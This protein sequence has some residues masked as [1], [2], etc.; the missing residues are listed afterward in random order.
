MGYFIVILAVATLASGVMLFLLMQIMNLEFYATA[1]IYGL[2]RIG[3]VL[4]T[5]PL[6]GLVTIYMM[7]LTRP[8]P[9]PIT[10][11]QPDFVAFY[12]VSY[13]M[14]RGT[15][16]QKFYMRLVIA[17]WLLGVLV[18]T[19]VAVFQVFQFYRTVLKKSTLVTDPSILQL[20][21]TVRE[22]LGIRK[23]I[24]VHYH[25]SVQVPVLVILNSPR[26]LIGSTDFSPEELSWIIRHELVHLKRKHILFK[27]LGVLA[28]TLYWF[29][30]LIYY[31]FQFFSDYCELDC[32]RE[33]LKGRTGVQR[34]FYANLLLDLLSKDIPANPAIES[35]FCGRT[36]QKTIDRR[37]KNIIH[38]PEKK[39]RVGILALSV[40]YI[41]SCPFVTFGA[42]KAGAEVA[43]DYMR[44]TKEEGNIKSQFSEKY[45]P[46][47]ERIRTVEANL[48][49]SDRGASNI[50]RT[51]SANKSIT[52]SVT[53]S[54]SSVWIGLCSDSKSD[55]FSISFD[56]YR[57]D[58]SNNGFLSCFFDTK[59]N[60][61]YKLYIDSNMD[62]SIHIAGTIRN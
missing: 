27:R 19:A 34:L 46:T 16:L 24:P 23:K 52:V 25:P 44:K 39:I 13:G 37:F 6:F 57:V 17:A 62:H 9:I 26:I 22:E 60:K 8:V 10:S 15:P 45:I 59:P 4:L 29:N 2:L 14:L 40:F 28:Q 5:L 43:T 54:S 53:A 33:V 56:G 21:K 42:T 61:T 18:K 38:K 32:D 48:E 3:L 55:S 1:W 12:E 31:F 35:A 7:Y 20:V 36:K 51:I 30:P 11:D 58:S 41:L 49:V 47:T 50:S